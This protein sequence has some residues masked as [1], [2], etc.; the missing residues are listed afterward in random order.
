[1]TVHYKEAGSGD[2]SVFFM[3]GASFSSA[4]WQDIKTLHLVAAMGY[5]AVAVDIPGIF[6]HFRYS[7]IQMTVFTCRPSHHCDDKQITVSCDEQ[8]LTNAIGANWIMWR[9]KNQLFLAVRWFEL[10]TV[11]LVFLCAL[12]FANLQPW[13]LHKNNGLQICV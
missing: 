7:F 9:R 12:Y 8:K 10:I 1:V 3:H 13:W 11:K 6:C 4:T 2:R 5:R